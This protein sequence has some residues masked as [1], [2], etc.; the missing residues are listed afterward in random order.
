MLHREAPTNPSERQTGPP[1]LSHEA[2]ANSPGQQTGPP[3]PPHE[4]LRT[5]N[6]ARTPPPKSEPLGTASSMN[7]GGSG[8]VC[9][10]MHFRLLARASPFS[11]GENPVLG[12]VHHRKGPGSETIALT[13]ELPFRPV[14]PHQNTWEVLMAPESVVSEPDLFKEQ[15]AK[16]EHKSTSTTKT[17]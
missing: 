14:R 11:H 16:W 9:M 10:Y 4:V 15:A 1:R 3:R 2:P 5:A 17:V 6:W 13:A 7:S 12:T 8:A